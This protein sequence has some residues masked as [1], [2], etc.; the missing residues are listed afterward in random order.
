MV[1]DMICTSGA[2]SGKI[3]CVV[4]SVAVCAI[5]FAKC[6]VGVGTGVGVAG[7]GVASHEK[8]PNRLDGNEKLGSHPNPER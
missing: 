3:N 8:P 4:V 6:G 2:T 7:S 5:S 1:V